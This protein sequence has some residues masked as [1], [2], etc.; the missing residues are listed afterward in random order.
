MAVE[1]FG[2]LQDL[3]EKNSGS[4]SAKKHWGKGSIRVDG[5]ALERGVRGGR[6]LCKSERA[7]K[8]LEGGKN[9]RQ[10]GSEAEAEADVL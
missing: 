3:L 5:V 10:L 8:G 9:C 2:W 1:R 6:D 7:K 4:N